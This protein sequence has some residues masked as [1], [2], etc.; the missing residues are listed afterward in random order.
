MADI[1]VNIVNID[2][3]DELT[4]CFTLV[5]KGDMIKVDNVF[6]PETTGIY[7]FKTEKK[8]LFIGK[9]KI[10]TISLTED[11]FGKDNY[12][13]AFINKIK[14]IS[15][16]FDNKDS[17]KYFIYASYCTKGDL[18]KSY[19]NNPIVFIKTLDGNMLPG[20]TGK[21][22]SINKELEEFMK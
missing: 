1:K 21:C 4:T 10:M 2:N 14:V 19:K 18:V 7:V 22:I 11:F 12:D 13:L 9:N 16:R 17:K 3:N 5:N 8:L 6:D 20:M 15:T